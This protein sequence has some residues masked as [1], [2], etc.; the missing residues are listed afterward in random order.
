MK[1]VKEEKEEEEEE[2][3]DYLFAAVN[4]ARKLRVDPGV[5]L[6]RANAKFEARF[7]AMEH[8]AGGVDAFSELDLDAQEALWQ[9]V[10]A[11]GAS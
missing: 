5:A 4:L 11:G 9:R 2:L 1:N 6:R 3:G 8:L 10:K 7:R